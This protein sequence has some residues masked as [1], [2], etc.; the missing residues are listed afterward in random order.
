MS[1][2]LRLVGLSFLFIHLAFS[3]SEKNFTEGNGTIK[4]EEKDGRYLSNKTITHNVRVPNGKRAKLSF[5]TFNVLGSM[6][7][8]TEDSLEIFV[9]NLTQETSGNLFTPQWPNKYPQGVS[10]TWTLSIPKDHDAA[11]YLMNFRIEDNSQCSPMSIADDYVRITASSGSS[12]DTI[13]QRL[14]SRYEDQTTIITVNNYH[15]VYVKFFSDTDNVTSVESGFAAG[16]L[17]YKPGMIADNI[18]FPFFL[19]CLLPTFLSCFLPFFVP[20]FLPSFIPSFLPSFLP[21]FI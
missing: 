13:K 5:K 18:G 6:P 1:V 2:L 15:K 21:S 9:G 19:P 4:S 10:C 17:S 7:N 14:C 11:I 3:S 20:F 8:C 16:F 12:N